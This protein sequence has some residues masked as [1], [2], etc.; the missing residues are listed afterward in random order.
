L[1]FH[2]SIWTL[3]KRM[4]T[5]TQTAT[6]YTTGPLETSIFLNKLSFKKMKNKLL[7]TLTIILIITSGFNAFSQKNEIIKWF[8]N[9]N[10]VE[11]KDLKYINPMNI[12]SLN[13]YKKDGVG[14]IYI[15][16]KKNKVNFISVDDI[17]KKYT[18]LNRSSGNVLIII[19]NEVIDDLSDIRIDDTYFIY[20]ITKKL[21][22]NQYLRDNFRELVIVNI[23]LET[24]ERK[25]GINLRGSERTSIELL[26]SLNK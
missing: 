5:L 9:S 6:P 13:T 17:L 14:Y 24:K 11:S 25:T 26:D 23:S 21:I 7:I 4:P 15:K 19:K 22:E 3:Q 1:I 12:D 8:L 18:T 20:V 2:P 10:Q 16:T